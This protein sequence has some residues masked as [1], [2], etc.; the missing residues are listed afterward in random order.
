MLSVDCPDQPWIQ[1]R[2]LVKSPFRASFDHT[3]DT[4]TRCPWQ[5]QASLA[6]SIDLSDV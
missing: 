2:V 6:G 5:G 3:V 1:G 4:N